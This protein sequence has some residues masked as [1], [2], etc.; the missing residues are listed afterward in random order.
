M[1]DFTEKGWVGHETNS[2]GLDIEWSYWMFI[3]VGDSYHTSCSHQQWR[4]SNKKLKYMMEAFLHWWYIYSLFFSEVEFQNSFHWGHTTAFLVIRI[5]FSRKRSQISL[6]QLKF[7]QED[8]NKIYWEVIIHDY[9]LVIKAPSN[10]SGKFNSIT[11]EL[12]LDS[13]SNI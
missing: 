13:K 8:R 4:N 6:S 9:T 10:L 12:Y 11:A 5:H 3:N 2:W 1:K 7:Q